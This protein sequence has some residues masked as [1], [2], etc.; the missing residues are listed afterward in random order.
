MGTPA[1]IS[2]TDVDHMRAALVLAA[3]GLGRVAPNPSVGCV[4]TDARG[5]VAG[6]GWTQ[7]GGRP[8]GETEALR[9]A[10]EGSRGGTA[11]VTLEPCDHHGET[12][13][14]SQALIDAGLARVV[15]ACRDPDPRVA[16]RGIARL[17]AAGLNV[18]EGILEQEALALNAGFFLRLKTGRPLFTLK[19]ATSLD[20][21]I[22]THGGDSRWIT[23]GEARA[24]GH[25]LRARHDAILIGA[26]TAE[27]D[28]PD[29]T[30]RLPG[31]DSYSPLRVVADSTLRLSPASRLAETAETTPTLA[32]AAP[33][34]DAD[35]ARVLRDRG[36][37]VIEADVGAERRP[38]PEAI[39]R[40]LAGKGLTRVLIEGG[41]TLA[42][43][44]MAAGLV[45][46]LAWFHAP[47]LIGGDGV[48][49]LAP[50]GVD[51]LSDGPS[52]RR[53]G[54]FRCGGD[55]LETY[56]REGDA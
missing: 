4:I 14:C 34:A 32:I 31:M 47:K 35:K 29:L 18:E 20:G 43:S 54:L 50:F 1:D 30:C 49:A 22:A 38:T 16:G 52:F 44:F 42:G 28:D 25:M 6:R 19:A 27:T 9:R 48:P 45:D 33:G 2:S 46:C 55:I 10:G 12:P 21:R 37:E 8:H 41:G 7:P 56:E 17:Q 39:A 53:T 24:L 36:V 5:R 23:G 3:R 51:T 26:G 13:P 15:V 40:V 11:Y